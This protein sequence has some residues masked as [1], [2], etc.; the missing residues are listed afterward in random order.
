MEN[1]EAGAILAKASQ[2]GFIS[3]GG[4]DMLAASLGPRGNAAFANWLQDKGITVRE[5]P[6][7]DETEYDTEDTTEDGTE[8]AL[9]PFGVNNASDFGRLYER[10]MLSVQKAAQREGQLRKQAFEQAQRAIEANRFG[11]PSRS[12]QLAQLA[13]AMLS[14]TKIGGFK[15]LMGNIA[16]VIADQ[17]TS[18]READEKRAAALLQLRQQ[19]AQGQSAADLTAAKESLAA[20]KPLVSLYKP[21]SAS[22]QAN[23]ATGEIF[24]TK[25]GRVLPQASHIAAL[26]ANP[27]KADQFDMKFWPGAAAEILASYGKGR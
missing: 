2:D 7:M 23:A 1:S 21:Q 6:V 27:E 17:A 5:Q 22:Y 16:P 4:R 15:G 24:N 8:G 3:A 26:I 19:Y 14:P 13:K 12:E 25:T 20:L 9:P 11:A 10:S 18:R